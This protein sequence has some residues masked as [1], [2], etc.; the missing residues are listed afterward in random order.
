MRRLHRELK[1]Y[2][3]VKSPR[4]D[5]ALIAKFISMSLLIFSILFSSESLRQSAIP[6]KIHRTENGRIK[7][8]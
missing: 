1:W 3:E 6:I 4:E 5:F 8:P 2:M 7:S